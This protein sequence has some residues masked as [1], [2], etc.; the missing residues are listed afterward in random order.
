MLIQACQTL[1]VHTWSNHICAQNR[2]FSISIWGYKICDPPPIQLWQY[3]F[4]IGS[5]LVYLPPSPPKKRP[6]AHHHP[7]V[8]V[9]PRTAPSFN[10]QE[11]N[12]HIVSFGGLQSRSKGGNGLIEPAGNEPEERVEQSFKPMVSFLLVFLLHW[13]KIAASWGPLNR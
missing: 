1:I 9:K 8:N 7:I 12:R 5:L 6:K 13:K 10:V 4:H 11:P 3:G 2:R